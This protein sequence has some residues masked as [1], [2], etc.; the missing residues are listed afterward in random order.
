MLKSIICART[1]HHPVK[2]EQQGRYFCSVGIGGKLLSAFIAVVFLTVAAGG[3]AFLSY[4]SIGGGLSQIESQSL[5]RMNHA[6]TFAKKSAE[7]AKISVM[8]ASATSLEDLQKTKDLLPAK[9]KSMA[10]SLAALTR[11]GMPGEAVTK[12]KTASE[13]LDLSIDS[14]SETVA[15]RI[16]NT[17]ERAKMLADAMAAHAAVDAKIVPLSDATMASVKAPD[18]S[19]E[20]RAAQIALV[21]R[22][23]SIRAEANLLLGVLAEASL[24]P[25]TDVLKPIRERAIAAA[26]QLKQ[27]A[28]EFSADPQTTEIPALLDAFLRFADDNSGVGESRYRELELMRDSWS[29]ALVNAEK[30]DELATEVEKAATIAGHDA[31]RAVVQS[32]SDITRAEVVLAGLVLASLVFAALAWVFIRS[33]ILHRLHHL[34]DAILSL[35]NGDLTTHVPA[36]G[37]DEIAHMGEAVEIFKQ[38]A[39]RVRELEAR[40]TEERDAKERR[41]QRM[42]EYI[43]AFEQSGKDLAGSLAS[44]SSEIE[45]SARDMSNTAT[46]T[47][48]SATAVNAAAGQAT[49]AV[50]SVASAVEELSASIREITQSIETSTTVAG[51]AVDEAKHADN[52]MQGLTAAAGEIGE[53]IKLIEEI[54]SQTNLLALNA[55]IEAARAGEAGKGFAVVASE[56]KSLAS[57]TA[58][59]TQDIRTKISTV[60]SAVEEAVQAISR[61]DETINQI[62]EIGNTIA[63][64]ISQQEAATGEIALATQTAAESA[65]QVSESIRVV[66]KAAATTDTAADHV[67]TAALELGQN[68]SALREGIHNFLTKIRAA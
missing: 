32:V 45:A 25:N 3:V 30:A 2:V 28:A 56:V 26:E 37:S 64:A 54:A 57:Q 62:S 24:A 39:I 17:N 51:R 22:L 7:M 46:D 20:Q 60:Q 38:N 48:H 6:L 44:A 27:A 31:N 15:W 13:D 61:V 67:V 16:E 66:D 42:E 52:I 18:Q 58:H 65:A 53:V 40:Q 43:A 36:D 35:V 8:L 63:F 9:R 59:A 19:A 33:N 47:S 49:S 68:V 14:L 11:A 4:R 29:L 23:A 1:N 50:H 55:T 41:Q 12:L 34:S 21:E 5:P 10:D